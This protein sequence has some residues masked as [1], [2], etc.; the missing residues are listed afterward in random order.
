MSRRKLSAQRLEQRHEIIRLYREAH[1]NR[2]AATVDI[3]AWAIQN[4]LYTPKPVDYRKQLA[5]ELSRAM[6]EEFFTD[7]QGRRVRAKHVAK[8]DVNGKQQNL[9]VDMRD[10]NPA[11]AKLKIISLQN[12]RQQIVGDCRQLKTD[13]DS[14]KA[15]PNNCLLPNNSTA[16]PT[17]ILRY[18]KA[19]I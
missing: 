9:W 1:K 4:N 2:P 8:M 3:A 6:S 16:C 11:A 12:R 13:V 17:I 15:L 19:Y 18:E 7:P 10:K 14:F 5:E